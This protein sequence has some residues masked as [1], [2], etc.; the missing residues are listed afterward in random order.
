[1]T[2]NIAKVKSYLEITA[3]D[4]DTLLTDLAASVGAFIEG[5]CGRKFDND[6]YVEIYSGDGGRFLYL[7]NY[8]ISAVTKIEYRNG[9]NSNPNW[10]ELS[11][12]DYYLIDSRSIAKDSKFIEGFNNYRVTYSAGYEELP[13][14]LLQVAIEMIAKKFNGRKSDGI[15]DE[16]A[17][18]ASITWS[19]SLT[20]EQ[21]IVLK[22]FKKVLL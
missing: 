1:M 21:K 22:R 10:Q 20:E 15:S 4:F 11:S 17:E 8:P 19:R 18:S 3:S 13:A 7:K 12:D 14:E 9:P 2:I 16:S 6:D 5:Y